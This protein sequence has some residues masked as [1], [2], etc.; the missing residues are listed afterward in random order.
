MVSSIC[1]HKIHV[2]MFSTCDDNRSWG[3]GRSLGHEAGVL[4]NKVTTFKEGSLGTFCPS[5]CHVETSEKST[6][7]DLREPSPQPALVGT[8]VLE[9][10]PPDLTFFCSQAR[11][12]ILHFYRSQ[13]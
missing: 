6:T 9:F 7:C 10:W 3:L 13:N 1:P 5:F 11:E 8:V 2:S 12:C 4:L